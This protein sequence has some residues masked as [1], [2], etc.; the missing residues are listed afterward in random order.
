LP[1]DDAHSLFS[2]KNKK[3]KKQ[4]ERQWQ[5]VQTQ[6]KKALH[7]DPTFLTAMDFSWLHFPLR[8][9]SFL[10]FPSFWTLFPVFL[11]LQENKEP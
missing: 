3:T 8:S 10:V 6:H 4:G 7:N 1:S 5:Q 9:S 2:Q 11:L